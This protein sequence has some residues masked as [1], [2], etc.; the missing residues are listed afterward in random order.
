[1]KCGTDEFIVRL[2]FVDTPETDTK[3]HERSQ[4]QTEYFGV[5]L[6]NNIQAGVQARDTV[7]ELLRATP[8]VIWTRKASAAGRSKEP[9]YYGLV[10]VGGK[11]LAEILLNRGLARTKGVIATLPSG[12]KAKVYVEKLQGLENEAKQRR[13]GIWAHSKAP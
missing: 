11:S 2:Y 1:V 6:E 4:E 9:R 3:D 13:V 8:F 5:T 12:E 10:E 7:D